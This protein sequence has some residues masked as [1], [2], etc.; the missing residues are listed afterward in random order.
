MAPDGASRLS[1]GPSPLCAGFRS[2]AR[3]PPGNRE[4][5]LPGNLRFCPVDF[6][7]TSLSEGLTAAGFDVSTPACFSW[8]GVTQYLTE[9]A[10]ESTFRFVSTLAAGSSI[11]FTFILPVSCLA[12][13]DA[14]LHAI[15]AARASSHGEPWLTQYDPAILRDR[16][17]EIGFSKVTHL[18]AEAASQRY[19]SDRR[20]GL[21]APGYEELMWATV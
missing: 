14:Q 4:C 6:E 11:V 9:E 5:L 7:S 17:C 16:L 20:D 2:G 12:A 18:T 21:R 8:L 10:T 19:F 3:S 15:A 13:E 1:D